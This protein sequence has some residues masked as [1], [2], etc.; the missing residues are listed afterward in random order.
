MRNENAKYILGIESSCDETSASVV[1]DDRQILSNVVLSQTKHFEYGGVVPELAARAHLQS[2]D[3]IILEAM[4][5]AKL[6]FADLDG[7]A[8]T[9][10]PGLIGG[11]IIGTMTA[12]GIALALN[13]PYFA[14]N[15]LEAH[16]L[17]ARLTDDIPFPYLLL[18]VSGGHCQL[19]IVKDVGSYEKLGTTIDDAIGEAF[20]KTGRLLGFSYPAGPMIE[21]TA[22]HGDPKKFNLPKP[23]H[24]RPGCDFSFSGLKTAVRKVIEENPEK[25]HHDDQ[26]KADL[27]ASFQYTIGEILKD[28]LK[29]GLNQFKSQYPEAKDFVLA[30][31]V[32]ANQYLR[33][34]LQT[35]CTNHDLTLTAP[36]IALCT[37]NAAMIAWVGQE[38]LRENQPS[39]LDFAPRPRWPLEELGKLMERQYLK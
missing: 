6:D 25:A 9:A 33:D 22:K 26:F 5:Q 28:R 27:C 34:I 13:K 20:D 8:A 24:G 38:K 36:P 39:G 18:L 14:I 31:G 16:A 35:V 15:H 7:I 11:V 2:I 30:G 19:L 37:D 12:K 3:S 21:R 10:G 4:H 17:T 29:N 1:T 32:A 23:L